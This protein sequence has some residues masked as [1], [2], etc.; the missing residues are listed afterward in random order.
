MR[1][2]RFTSS[3][4]FILLL[5]SFLLIAFLRVI[6]DSDIWFH[7]SFGREILNHGIP[8]REF[9]VFTRFGESADYNSWGFGSIYFLIWEMF[10]SAGMALANASLGA[11]TLIM[12]GTAVRHNSRSYSLPVVCLAITLT[13]IWLEF[14][15]VYRP[16][17]VLYLATASAIVLLERYL[18]DYSIRWLWPIPLLSLLV[19]LFHPSAIIL[20]GIT[21]L[22]AAQ[23]L[24]QQRQNK[25]RLQQ[26][27]KAQSLILVAAI[28]MACANPLGYEQL[29]MPVRFTLGSSVT[30]SIT[31]FLPALE[32]EYRYHFISLA[33]FALVAIL[34]RRPFRPLDLVLYC[35]FCYL[36]FK[37]VRNIPLLAIISFVPLSSFLQQLWVTT[38]TWLPG[39]QSLK[40]TAMILLCAATILLTTAN[41]KLWGMGK[42][43]GCCPT[44]SAN[45]I[46]EHKPR[47]RLLNFYDL[48]N[49]LGWAL[50]GEYPV[51]ID[52]R[53]NIASRGYGM[54]NHIF[55]A[56]TGWQQ[57][58]N[59]YDIRTIITRATLD[60]SG[61]LIPL[62]EILAN[63][64]QWQ[65]VAAEPAGL[66]FIHEK[67]RS[68]LDV[69]PIKDPT[70]IWK[71]VL[72]ET[73]IT[74]ENNPQ[75][76][77][78]Y[79]SRSIAYLHLN[80]EKLARQSYLLFKSLGGTDPQLDRKLTAEKPQSD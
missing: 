30:P 31:E 45:L 5:T 1:L 21:G 76:A 73:D 47:G 69:P 53:N 66:T 6:D 3:Y 52:G 57:L 67:E 20:I 16:E 77:D 23:A 42:K 71:Q 4:P 34:Y 22:Y 61:T 8:D 11:A 72:L 35:L 13:Y 28:A 40:G 32:T 2:T 14:R 37:H 54:H 19:T 62:V 59:L 29:I 60:Y 51:F 12:L 39:K 50:R 25:T 49:Y 70:V 75:S 26:L 27:L 68:I 33:I 18:R 58:L 46:H 38:G 44:A 63:Q 78:I 56:D 43:H 41:T 74:L 55:R 7:L 17:T 9:L 64:D 79:R 10:G 48:G 65:L 15:Y 80:E 24:W 36:A